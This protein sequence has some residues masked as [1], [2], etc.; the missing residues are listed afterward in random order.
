VPMLQ[1]ATGRE[2]SHHFTAVHHVM[3]HYPIHVLVNPLPG[4]VVAVRRRAAVD[5]AYLRR[6][7]AHVVSTGELW[8][9]L[10]FV[11]HLGQVAIAVILHR[12]I[13]GIVRRNI[14]VAII[15]QGSQAVA[16]VEI[17]KVIFGSTILV[18]PDQT[19]EVAVLVVGQAF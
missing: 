5:V 14:R 16:L 15:N 3:F 13:R 1:G 8:Y 4:G 12:D 17:S 19:R 11:Q 7:V 10:Y 9:I 2:D 18:P 6:Q